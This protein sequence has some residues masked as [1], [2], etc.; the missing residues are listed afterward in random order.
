MTRAK[1]ILSICLLLFISVSVFGQLPPMPTGMTLP[2]SKPKIVSPKSKEQSASLGAKMVAAP[3]FV[4]PPSGL[5]ITNITATNGVVFLAWQGNGTIQVLQSPD[6]TNWS[7]A[8][9]AI[10]GNSTTVPQVGIKGYYRLKQLPSMPP[11]APL[12]SVGMIGQSFG[13]NVRITAVATNITGV[14]VCGVYSTNV[15]F[16]GIWLTN[17]SPNIQTFVASYADDGSLRWVNGFTNGTGLTF[18]AAISA[19]DDAVYVTGYFTVTD[20]IEGQSIISAGFDDIFALK[21]SNS[22]ALAWVQRYG[23]PRNDHGRAI[24]PGDAGALTLIG[25]F[26]DTVQF[27]SST[28]TSAGGLDILLGRLNFGNGSA[29]SGNAYGGA[30]DEFV[31]GGTV[32]GSGNFYIVGQL[33]GAGNFGGGPVSSPAA[34]A[35]FISKYDSSFGYSWAKVFGTT[36]FNNVYGVT[37]DPSA[38]VIFT[39]SAQGAIDYGGGTRVP[40]G[41]SAITITRLT[42]SG[43]YDMDRMFGGTSG[44]SDVGRSVSTDTA[45]NIYFGG[46]L[47]S[48]TSFD[49]IFLLGATPDLLLGK[50]NNAGI[51][52][53]AKRYGGTDNLDETFGV[54]VPYAGGYFNGSVSFDGNGGSWSGPF[55]CQCGVLWK[56]QP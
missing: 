46:T 8:T 21:F 54:S 55:N 56:V 49:S 20:Q 48:S 52:Q 42:S 14:V 6:L 13:K 47:V 29:I 16:G 11:G 2:V 24:I 25:E 5:Y 38:K 40:G 12:W 19:K 26:S 36:G 39:G 9:P 4:I 15:N 22:G 3:R 43:A 44:G 28:L 35:Q 50:L 41:G 18:P 37:T 32:D 10:E 30:G 1:K 17:R 33:I 51:T 45:G 34:G 27:G 23:G 53:W 7:A 31:N